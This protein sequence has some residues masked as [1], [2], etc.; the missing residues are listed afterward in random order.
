MFDKPEHELFSILKRYWNTDSFR[1]IGRYKINKDGNTSTFENIRDQHGDLL[2]FPVIE[3]SSINGG[4]VKAFSDRIFNLIEGEYYQFTA[5][6]NPIERNINKNPLYVKSQPFGHVKDNIKE[7]L[8][9]EALV[10]TIFKE[11]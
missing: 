7:R 3:N 9:K 8:E 2:Y 10:K 11:K 1:F 5:E 4:G 6:I